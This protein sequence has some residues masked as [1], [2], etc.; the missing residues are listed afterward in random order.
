MYSIIHAKVTHS[1]SDPIRRSTSPVVPYALRFGRLKRVII[2]VRPG[3]FQLRIS[4]SKH[5]EANV[6]ASVAFDSLFHTDNFNNKE[7]LRYNITTSL[8]VCYRDK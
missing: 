1:R 3:Q 5:S 8:L 6:I 4:R 7:E 2:D